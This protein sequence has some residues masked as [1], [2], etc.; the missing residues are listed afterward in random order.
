[1]RTVLFLCTGNYYR[2][3]FAEE[4]FNARAG[5]AGLNWRAASR[6]LAIE[7]GK[8][9]VGPVSALV[10]SALAELGVVPAGVHRF[11]ASCTVADFESADLIIALSDAE[12]RP[13]MLERYAEWHARTEFWDIEDVGL[14]PSRVALPA[15]QER[16]EAL[17]AQL[18][19]EDVNP[20]AGRT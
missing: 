14:T 20:A 6:G 1:M 16:I 5:E 19:A 10:R 17:V 13:L 15:I 9:N 18:T 8:D 2:S 3:R 11:P 7:R 4:L 12:H